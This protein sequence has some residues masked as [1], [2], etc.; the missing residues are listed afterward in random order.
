MVYNELAPFGILTIGFENQS[1]VLVSYKEPWRNGIDPDV[2]GILLSHV[3]SKPFG[4]VVHRSFGS[5]IRHHS[6]HRMERRGGR[7]VH[8]L[9]AALP[10]H[11]GSKDLGRK[12]SPKKI[13]VQNVTNGF[14]IEVKKSLLWIS[15]SFGTIATGSV[16]ENINS[17]K[18]VHNLIPSLF[19]RF[20]TQYIGSH[21]DG[22]P[23]FS[24]DGFYHRLHLGLCA[25]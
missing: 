14:N 10:C 25:A 7:N 8:N 17:S 4:E 1:A 21:T 3:H 16:Y 6:C 22:L 18:G 24:A 12:N 20:L 5:R 11:L 15:S 19:N 23:A 13:E 2:R 9:P